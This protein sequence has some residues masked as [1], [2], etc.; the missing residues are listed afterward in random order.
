VLHSRDK[1][2]LEL[3]RSRST[4]TA[5]RRAA[6]NHVPKIRR[7]KSRLHGFGVFAAEPINKNKRI[8]DYAGELI[9]N[10]QSRAR[11]DR[12][13]RTGCIW[14]FRV[15]RAWS[16]DAYVGGNVARFINHSCRPNCWVDVVDK[17]IWIRAARNIEAGEELT[18]DYNTEGDKT[19]PCRCRPGCTTRL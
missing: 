7:R 10:H 8:I 17:T 18:Y 14:V 19:I 5:R 4:K 13:L 6:T 11:E 2:S 12:Y 3:A 1:V 16:R 15:N 9:T